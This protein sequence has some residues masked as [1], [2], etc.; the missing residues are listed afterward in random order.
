M[1]LQKSP[2]LTPGTGRERGGNQ[3]K[4]NLTE[5]RPGRQAVDVFA[6]ANKTHTVPEVRKMLQMPKAPRVQ[7]QEGADLR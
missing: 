1:S 6:R 3:P 5:P 2:A 7:V 4:V